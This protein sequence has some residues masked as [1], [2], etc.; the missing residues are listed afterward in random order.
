[1]DEEAGPSQESTLFGVYEDCEVVV[2]EF[3]LW[4]QEVPI[5]GDAAEE[6]NGE[7]VVVVGKE[8]AGKRRQPAR[9][10]KS[11]RARRGRRF[12]R[13]KHSGRQPPD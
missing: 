8:D 13:D 3:R 10:A 7:K 5:A 11:R 9:N 1:M 2:E 12:E 4:P 6:V